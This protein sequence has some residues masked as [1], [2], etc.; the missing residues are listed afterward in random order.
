MHFADLMKT[1][2]RNFFVITTGITASIYIFCLIFTPNAVFSVEDIGRI[3]LMAVA[4]DLPFVIFYSRKEPDK[5]QMRI[6]FAIH[7]PV[8]L[9][10]LLYFAHLWDWVS[11]NDPIEV[12]VLIL[13]IM[14]VYAIVLAIG[15]YLDRK[16]A[17]KLNES[18][19]K[20]YH[21]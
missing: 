21:S 3:L 18:L 5:K 6:R 17:E 7:I 16:T 13:L 9:A 20:R 11:L 15:A 8:L 4:G 2:L 1:M 10:I 14:V 19:K 12:A